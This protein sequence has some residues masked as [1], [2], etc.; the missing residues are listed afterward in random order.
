MGVAFT[1]TMC[2]A[3][4]SVAVTQDGGRSLSA[5]ASTAAH[6][7]GHIFNMGHDG[8]STRH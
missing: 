2:S 5:V 8:I 1:H 6:E 3:T 7:L 4:H